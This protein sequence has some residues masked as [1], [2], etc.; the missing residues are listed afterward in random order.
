MKTSDWS[1]VNPS[2]DKCYGLEK[3]KKKRVQELRLMEFVR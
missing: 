1:V 2:H 3:K